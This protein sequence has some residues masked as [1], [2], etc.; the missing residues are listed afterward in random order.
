MVATDAQQTLET[1]PAS[2]Q[3]ASLVEADAGT[4]MLLLTRTTRDEE[5]RVFE[6]V[7]SLYRGDRYRFLTTLVPPTEGRSLQGGSPQ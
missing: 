7:R 1:V 5:G 3:V 4:P 6:F 2:P